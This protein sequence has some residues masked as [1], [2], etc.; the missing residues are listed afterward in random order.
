MGEI[1]VG[2]SGF[3]FDDWMG[4]VYPSDTKKGEMLPYYEHIL[5]FNALEVNY[6]YY[7]MPSRKTME[8]F[9]RR[10]SRG[11]SFVVKAH[12]SI[13]HERAANIEEQCKLF[14]E[15]VAP[16]GE[17]LKALL[18]QFPYGFLPVEEN[19][20]YLRKL[21]EEFSCVDSIVEFRNGRWLKQGYLDLLKEL[22]LGF[23]VV[24]EPKLKGLLPF[25][26]VL[27]SGV[28]YFRFHGRNTAWFNEPVDV[29]Y[30]YLYTE[31]ELAGF[32]PAIQE[33]GEKAVTT[34]VFFNNCHAGKAAKNAQMMVN[35]LKERSVSS[36]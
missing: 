10:T 36:V 13:T 5:G 30:N 25:S 33:I 18:F 28:G 21:K 29:R 2:T 20:G 9:H 11:F 22:S 32:V 23:C 3:S 1:L 14:R 7:T 26:P 27:T 19:V 31:E 6:T 17:N 8:S 16:L 35:M 24:D 15:G 4:E 12:K 34:F